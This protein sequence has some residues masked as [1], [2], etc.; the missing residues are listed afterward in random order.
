M[1][2]ARSAMAKGQLK[3]AANAL[4]LADIG[5]TTGGTEVEP[6]VEARLLETRAELA[7]LQHHGSAAVELANR[8]ACSYREHGEPSGAAR[9]LVARASA[10]RGAAPTHEVVELEQALAAVDAFGEPELWKALVAELLGTYVR[11]DDVGRAARIFARLLKD[12]DK[13]T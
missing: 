2:L 8:A 1:A 4:D 9:C 11:T 12:N 5:F 6:V 10:R 7:L 13:E 3:L